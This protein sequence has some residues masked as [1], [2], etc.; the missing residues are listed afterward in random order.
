MFCLLKNAALRFGS[1][2]FLESSSFSYSFLELFKISVVFDEY[3]NNEKSYIVI[4][5]SQP[6][7]FYIALLFA[8]IRSNKIYLPISEHLA[9][10]Q[11]NSLM[12]ELNA[13]YIVDASVLY[14]EINLAHSAI[15]SSSNSYENIEQ[16][17]LEEAD[18][19]N[20]YCKLSTDS[21]FK[22][23]YDQSD[24]SP[25]LFEEKFKELQLFL[26][27]NCSSACNIMLSSGSTSTPKK[28]VHSL[29]THI[30]NAIGGQAVFKVN[31][32]DSYYLNMPLNHVGGQSILFK[33][34]LF[35]FKIILPSP[36]HSLSDLLISNKIS[37]LSMVPTQVYRLLTHEDNPLSK[38]KSLRAVL[39]GGA[40]IDSS[41]ISSVKCIAPNVKLYV[42]YGSTEMASQIATFEFKNFKK[43]GRVL[44]FRE[45]KIKD[46]EICVKG[47]TLTLGYFI[48]N[49]IVDIK[50]SDGYFHTKD[51]GEIVND[52]L[53]VLGRKDNMFISGGENIYPEKIEK[54]ILEL[55]YI[56]NALIVPVNSQ[57]WG[58]IAVAI[59]KFNSK[60]ESKFDK[61][62]QELICADGLVSEVVIDE[63]KR[64]LKSKLERAF[65]PKYYLLWPNEIDTSFKIKRKEVQQIISQ[66]FN[67]DNKK[68]R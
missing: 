58:N 55:D 67:F 54:V 40:H 30:Y 12:E 10:T 22:F 20:R 1:K 45:L 21:N 7:P 64:Y 29:A 25:L 35:G 44:P 53:F 46:G 63:L 48:D 15:R 4:I 28:I 9:E 27:S 19:L 8:C 65:V 39:L 33:S 11:I 18:L 23:N 26:D 68:S 32:S 5:K 47:K 2:T 34:L 31:S 52:E 62:S 41:L 24:F 51:L 43:V 37:L 16:Y 14:N 56:E 57:E 50:S 59:L 60:F 61:L 38:S 13:L 17:C 36:L 3:L 66:K 49:K 6:T 42:S